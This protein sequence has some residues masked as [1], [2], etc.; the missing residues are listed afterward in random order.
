MR[1]FRA[2]VVVAAALIVAGDDAAA[3]TTTVNADVAGAAEPLAAADAPPQRAAAADAPPPPEAPELVDADVASPGEAPAWSCAAPRGAADLVA[4]LELLEARFGLAP[5]ASAAARGALAPPGANASFAWSVARSAAP[6]LILRRPGGR[7]ERVACASDGRCEEHPG[8]AWTFTSAEPGC[9][10]GAVALWDDGWPGGRGEAARGARDAALRAAGGALL[11]RFGGAAASP[12]VVRAALGAAL[13]AAAG[14]RAGARL[15][16][17]WRVTRRGAAAALV[18]AALASRCLPRAA[19]FAAAAAAAVFTAGPALPP[20]LAEM[21]ATLVADDVVRVEF[22]SAS[23]V[24][25]KLSPAG[26]DAVAALLALLL[27]VGGAWVLGRP[28]PDA[29]DDD[30]DDC[31]YDD[32]RGFFVPALGFAAARRRAA[33]AARWPHAAATAVAAVVLRAAGLAAIASAP[34]DARRGAAAAAAAVLVPLLLRCR[35]WLATPAEPPR[36]ATPG[37][38]RNVTRAHLARLRAHLVAHPEARLALGN[39][40]PRDDARDA[41]LDRFLATGSALHSYRL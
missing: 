12:R 27:A 7:V 3:E 36:Y 11:W 17:T 29:G 21:L 32:G 25:V 8:G 38:R 26:G 14:S 37:A 5:R 4:A 18:A 23:G 1:I 2:L 13:G 31:V 28:D 20:A 24:V 9:V 22:G 30:D 41:E 16:R 33:A 34:R 10:L 15:P 40:G 39:R 6:S 35:R 19:A